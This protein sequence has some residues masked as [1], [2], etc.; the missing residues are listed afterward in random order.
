MNKSSGFTLREKNGVLYYTIPSFDRTNLVK[1]MFTTRVKGVSEFPFASLNLGINREDK[2]E[3]VKENFKIVC[4]VL[5]VSIDSLVFSNQVHGTNI[6]IVDDEDVCE[7]ILSLHPE[8]GVDGLLTN[9]R[10]LT[11][12]TFYADCVPIF[13][14]DYKK[15][16]IGLAHAGWRGTVGKIAGKMID[17]MIETYDC[18]TD[19]ILVGIGPSIGP[20]CYE[21]DEIVYEKFNNNF[22]NLEKLLISNDKG[23]WFLDL[24]AANMLILKCKGI[25]DK[26]ITVSRLCTSCNND[27]FYSYRKENGE[28]GRLAAIIHLI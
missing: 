11:L 16:V 19:N 5:D 20:C 21:V 26:N 18:N 13:F 17:K 9:K 22:T 2:I 15:K 4:N 25:L 7:E 8:E 6:K 10:D 27:K 14:L 12:C 1:H 3:N 24:W 28:T 23:K